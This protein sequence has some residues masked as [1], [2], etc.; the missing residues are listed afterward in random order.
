MKTIYK[1]IA[2]VAAFIAAAFFL[3]RKKTER[4]SKSIDAPKN[5]VVSVVVEEI[6]D[7]LQEGLGS[8]SDALS[9]DDPAD[10]LADLGNSRSRR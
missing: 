8:V 10:S 9:D 2:S 4:K 3:F 6:N 7:D 5:P 1:W